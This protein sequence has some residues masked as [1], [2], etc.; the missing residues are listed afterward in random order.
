MI[1]IVFNRT[2]FSKSEISQVEKG[3]TLT[4]ILKQYDYDPFYTKVYINGVFVPVDNWDTL[5]P[6]ED[7]I[8]NIINSPKFITGGAIFSAVFTQI[9]IAAVATV[10]AAYVG[11]KL[12]EVDIDDPSTESNAD[13]LKRLEG[14][15][16]DKKPYEPLEFPLGERRIYP[17]YVANP[18]RKWRNDDKEEIYALFW[19]GYGPLSVDRNSIRIGDTDIS[20]FDEFQYEFFDHYDQTSYNAIRNIWS[21]NF[22]Q[23]S[24]GVELEEDSGWG[25]TG[26]GAGAFTERT[27]SN[28]TDVDVITLNYVFPRGANRKG[29]KNWASAFEVELNPSNDSNRYVV[30]KYTTN[31]KGSPGTVCKINGNYY[32]IFPYTRPNDVNKVNTDDNTYL[33]P[34]GDIVYEDNSKN[35]IIF[36]KQKF[37]NFFTSNFGGAY[38]AENVFVRTA[39]AWKTLDEVKKVIEFDNPFFSSEL[40]IKTR[41]IYGTKWNTDTESPSEE[42]ETN[43]QINGNIRWESILTEQKLANFQFENLIGVNQIKPALMAIKIRSSNQ[44]SGNLDE[45]NLKVK[46][47]VPKD[48]NSDWTNY[49]SFSANDFKESNNPAE[50]FR[51]LCQGP[52]NQGRMKNHRLDLDNLK[53]WRDYCDTENFTINALIEEEITL[54]KLLDKVAKVGRARFVNYDGKYGVNIDRRKQVPVQIFTNKNSFNFST[55]K[56]FEDQSDGLKY[57]FENENEGFEK[58]EGIYYDPDL[59]VSERQGVFDKIELWGTTNPTQAAREAR[60]KFFENRLRR[61]VYSLDVD[62]EGLRC[63]TGD[64]V[65]IQNDII[66]IGL[67]SGRIQSTA[68]FSDEVQFEFDENINISVGNTYYFQIRRLNGDFEEFSAEY[69]G[70]HLWSTTDTTIMISPNDF[71]VY[72][73]Q[74]LESIEAVVTEI[75]NKDDYSVNLVLKRYDDELYDVDAGQEPEFES[76]INERVE[77]KTPSAPTVNV[78]PGSYSYSNR[79]IKVEVISGNANLPVQGFSLEYYTISEDSADFTDV[80]ENTDQPVPEEDDWVSAGFSNDGKFTIPVDAFLGTYY[81]FRA[82]TLSQ[83]GIY[84]PLSQE[85]EY[86]ISETPADSVQSFTVEE[87]T[88]TPKSADASFST[89][90]ITITEPDDKDFLYAIVEYRVQG[91]LN[92]QEVGKIGSDFED[93]QEQILVAD[94]TTYEFRVRSVSNWRIEASTGPVVSLTTTNTNDPDYEDKDPNIV[95]PVPDVNG[96]ELFEQGNDTEFEGRDAKFTWRKTQAQDWVEIGSEKKKGIGLSNILD[97]YFKDYQVEIWVNGS[98][99]RQENILDNVWEYTYEKNAEDYKRENGVGGAYREFEIRVYNRGRA[100]QLSFNAAKLV[101]NNPPAQLPDNLVLNN[102]Y[103]VIEVSYDKPE[104]SRDWAGVDV[105][106]ETTTGFDPETTEIYQSFDSDSFVISGLQQDQQYFVRIRPFDSFGKFG[107]IISSEFNIQTLNGQDLTGLS[108]WAYEIDPVDRTFIENNLAGDAVPSEKIVNITA[109]KITTGTLNATETITTEGIIRA[110]DDINNV[111]IQTSIGPFADPRDSITK[112]WFLSAF[113]NLETTPRLAFG[114]DELGNAFFSG[115][116]ENNN[117]EILADG[118]INTPNLTIDPDGNLD[119]NGNFSF[120][121][122]DDYIT[123]DQ[124]NGM[125]IKTSTLV[126]STPEFILREDGSAE[127]SGNITSGATITGSTLQTDFDGNERF[128]VDS[129]DNKAKFFDSNENQVITLGPTS[130]GGNERNFVIN[131][132]NNFNRGAYI[133][134]DYTPL[135]IIK[136]LSNTPA[137]T[138]QTDSGSSGPETGEIM[139]IVAT[140]DNDGSYN[141]KIFSE[142]D[143]SLTLLNDATFSVLQGFGGRIGI[144]GETYDTLTIGALVFGRTEGGDGAFYYGDTISGDQ[145]SASGVGN[146]G[147]TPFRS[148]EVFKCLGRSNLNRDQTLWMKVE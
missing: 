59:P 54:Q 116:I 111:D 99:V 94:G 98:L 40:K 72:G 91:Q 37:I 63:V 128:V 57:E 75:K 19:L 25:G 22:N 103:S 55:E 15:K 53:E 76:V 50:L 123:Y 125:E 48:W 66:D 10:A 77:N 74:G 109:A 82:R 65:R 110:V 146:S 36:D 6:S 61:Q 88:N 120:G 79:E 117:T 43:D 32:L 8:V 106:V 148:D 12:A 21:G 84:S 131:S 139:K 45:L 83:N 90:V 7:S 108:G 138:L 118:S 104:D 70:D 58:D 68:Y 4:E 86:I 78:G 147:S 101:V 67:G 64:R 30:A 129:T 28:A 31:N 143:G 5:K 127:F 3:V 137:F 52:M 114:I 2:P 60:F 85:V 136:R 18:F 145:I 56:S 130:V 27:I 112:T 14:L 16:N 34:F 38:S 41:Q 46:S 29:T 49:D 92:W 17:S 115:D 11:Y 1:N 9:A 140:S 97:Q 100:G 122:T 126:I 95:V 33:I 23:E 96:L 47:V 132:P 133:E 119:S 81:R 35:I 13:K 80:P 73:Q 42:E 142:G 87:K 62:F 51:W 134:T 24:I 20:D 135:T 102:G 144:G 89:A 39:S 105:W 141:T 113:K 121:G 26:D 44:F 93:R 124:T 71:G 107:A 69:L